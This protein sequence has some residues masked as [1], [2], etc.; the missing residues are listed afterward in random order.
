MG[1]FED[2][3]G[4]VSGGLQLGQTFNKSFGQD[5]GAFSGYDRG[6]KNKFDRFVADRQAS[7]SGAFNEYKKDAD[8]W[9]ESA[10]T[11]AGLAG[12]GASAKDSLTGL[13][14]AAQVMKGK[15]QTAVTDYI[16]KFKALRDEGKSIR[17]M[18]GLASA[19]KRGE[20]TQEIRNLTAADIAK[21]QMGGGFKYAEQ[22][23]NFGAEESFGRRFL[24]ENLGLFQD[25][26]AEFTGD[27]M[28]E[29]RRRIRSGLVNYDKY[30]ATDGSAPIEGARRSIDFS[31]V[32]LRTQGDRR[33]EDTQKLNLGIA[34]A[35]HAV[36]LQQKTNELFGLKRSD[37]LNADLQKAI[38]GGKQKEIKAARAAIQQ[39]EANG[40]PA[41]I[42]TNFS[43][44]LMADITNAFKV[45]GIKP[46]P[47]TSK[48]SISG[49]VGLPAGQTYSSALEKYNQQAKATVNKVIYRNLAKLSPQE[50]K[51]IN[52]SSISGAIDFTPEQLYSAKLLA[53]VLQVGNQIEGQRASLKVKFGAGLLSVLGKYDPVGGDEAAGLSSEALV[54][55]RAEMARLNG[56]VKTFLPADQQK[57]LSSYFTP[58]VNGDSSGPSDT[59]TDKES[60]WTSPG[61]LVDPIGIDF[62]TP[63]VYESNASKLL[64][65]D[66]R[67]LIA[68][69]GISVYNN[70]RSWFMEE[71]PN[72]SSKDANMY[73]AEA[74]RASVSAARGSAASEGRPVVPSEGRPVVP[75]EAKDVVSEAKRVDSSEAMVGVVPETSFKKAGRVAQEKFNRILGGD[76]ESGLSEEQAA[77]LKT[78]EGENAIANF[79][80]TLTSIFVS[81]AAAS[82]GRPVVPSEGRPVVPSEA[83]DVVSEAKRVDPSGA[84]RVDPSGAKRVDPS[85][86][87]SLV[88]RRAPVP[89]ERP[90]TE[91]DTTLIGEVRTS[92]LKPLLDMGV[93][94]KE[95]VSI[96]EGESGG[97]TDSRNSDTNASGLWQFMPIVAK[98]YGTTAKNI[99]AMSV[100]EQVQLYKRYLKK[101]KW[102][103]GVPLGMMQAAPAYARKPNTF[104][105]YKK[106]S[107]AWSKN[108][109]WR[110]ENGGDITVGS[111]KDYYINKER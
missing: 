3:I 24:R 27:R 39:H 95:L 37:N 110:P 82:E 69:E 57:I 8:F 32:D 4:G 79:L 41:H 19:F 84:K 87:R 101:N 40:I 16:N 75:S 77:A 107:S 7:V 6:T 44:D 42:N 34:Q 109:G 38:A 86:A 74:R 30:A 33:V 53:D 98:E 50:R 47:H 55:P 58:R 59:D 14:F 15:S 66:P 88:Q 106:G 11:L 78:K 70:A 99:R 21:M 83:K 102:E 20:N 54:V 9:S 65:G 93:P 89:R 31:G 90:D 43:T 104:V 28:A 80:K 108:P 94:L 73:A 48:V 46:P 105:V 10:K 91:P 36:A 1:F 60:N 64:G 85:G 2:F 52:M 63:G 49:Q 103:K 23:F 68:A 26:T 92:D 12:E 13:E 61:D 81:T 56:A 17:S 72:A 29:Q 97:L 18:E 51:H 67:A 22:K 100:K 96:L 111:I 25:S 71:Y 5:R 76:A 45:T 62:S 35:R